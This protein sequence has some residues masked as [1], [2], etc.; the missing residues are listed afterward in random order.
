MASVRVEF[1]PALA[2]VIDLVRAGDLAAIGL[3]MPIGLP[4]HGRRASDAAARRLLGAR[5]ASLFPT[6]PRAVLDARNYAD[7]LACCR[8]MDGAGLSR[9]AFNLVPKMRE[10][11]ACV[12]PDLQ[13]AVSEVHPETSFAAMGDQPCVHPKRRREGALER[14]ALLERHLGPIAA[15]VAARP[16]GVGVDDVLDACAAAWTALRVAAGTAVWLGDCD[17]RDARGLRLTIAV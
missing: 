7:A 16:I 2:P 15:A 6:P 17:A 9:Q 11:A 8:A 4:E 10:V 13:P 1:T 12:S 5:R 3:D 14:V